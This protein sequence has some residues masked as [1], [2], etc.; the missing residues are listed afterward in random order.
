[1]MKVQSNVILKS[2]LE[3]ILRAT[4]DAHRN[5]AGAIPMRDVQL[6]SA[7]F[8][9]ALQ[10]VGI[11]TGTDCPPQSLYTAKG[12]WDGWEEHRDA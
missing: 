2:D 9:A 6:Y 3:N 5:L 8:Q 1:M 10:A 7:G 12:G 4:W 11:A